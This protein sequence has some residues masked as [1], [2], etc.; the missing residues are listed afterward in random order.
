MS[1]QLTGATQ[2]VYARHRGVSRVYVNKLYHRGALVLNDD[3]TIN[4]PASDAALE[5]SN[6]PVRGGR[7]GGGIE[8]RTMHAERSSKPFSGDAPGS[9][10][11]AKRRDA[12]YVAKLRK[13]EYERSIGA[14][15]ESSEVVRAIGEMAAAV[16]S[17]DRIPDLVTTRMRAA[18]DD[19]TAHAMLADEI[20]SCRQAVADFCRALAERLTANPS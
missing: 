11:E 13:I 14:L 19:R 15:T 10:S 20:G 17:F 6:N 2:A 1:Q 16:N 7:G 3:G 5:A 8:T 18:P 12:D 4:V 9:L